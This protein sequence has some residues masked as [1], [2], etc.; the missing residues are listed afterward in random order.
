M[1]LQETERVEPGELAPAW[2]PPPS[3]Q[4]PAVALPV[5]EAV[6]PLEDLPAR[7]VVPQAA[8]HRGIVVVGNPLAGRVVA[9]PALPGLP[10]AGAAEQRGVGGAG[11][12][13]GQVQQQEEEEEEESEGEERASPPHAGGR[14]P[15]R[16]R[17]TRWGK[18]GVGDPVTWRRSEAKPRVDRRVGLKRLL[19]GHHKYFCWWAGPKIAKI[20]KYWYERI[21]GM[22][23]MGRVTNRIMQAFWLLE[24]E[25]G[26]KTNVSCPA[27]QSE[28][29][30]Q[31]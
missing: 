6:P 2:P 5:G 14:A 27:N 18:R 11:R 16:R 29:T 17:H 24:D 28:G 8:G 9:G 25:G 19:L 30:R 20:G 31:T 3:E 1:A 26:A 13:G 10:V 4:L 23:E 7:L 12:R 22:K 21:T 15:R